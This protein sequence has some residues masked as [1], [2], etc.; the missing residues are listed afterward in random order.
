MQLKFKIINK[1]F[2]FQNSYNQ[3]K[4]DIWVSSP[5]SISGELWKTCNTRKEARQYIKACNK[6]YHAITS[7]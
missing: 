7:I 1:L 3:P 4:W 5:S 2:G 6:I